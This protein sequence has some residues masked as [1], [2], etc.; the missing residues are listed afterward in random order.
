MR[1]L[2]ALAVGTMLTTASIAPAQTIVMRRHLSNM[3]KYGPGSPE[4]T[5][6]GSGTG[7]T[8]TPTPTPA[9]T[10]APIVADWV[11]GSLIVD[12]PSC[13]ATAPA[14]R[15]MSC[16]TAD[17]STVPESNCSGAKPEATGTVADYSGCSFSWKIGDWG[18]W[19]SS[20]SATATRDR[21]VECIRSDGTPASRATLCGDTVPETQEK[22]PNYTDCG[23]TLVNGD[24]EKGTMAGWT[25]GTILSSNKKE[26]SYAASLGAANAVVSQKVATQ[27][28]SYTL[29][30][31]CYAF[32][33]YPVRAYWNDVQVALCY[34]S[35]GGNS[36]W[37][38][39]PITATVTG[40]GGTDKLSFSATTSGRL[41]DKVV[42]SPVR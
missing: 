26:G 41:I 9:P 13:S 20:C 14:H 29:S 35:G 38:N 1:M 15:E 4:S 3:P 5:L 7:T 40:T 36:S 16:Q 25:G 11:Q 21:T 2:T 32:G 8:P 30:F 18:N 19:S 33:G 37:S 10:P 28:I 31:H 42:L 22:L 27:P 24:F 12:A 39:S 23:G 6:P 34:G 17:G